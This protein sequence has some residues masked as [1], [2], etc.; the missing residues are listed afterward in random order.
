MTTNA[1][2]PFVQ[3]AAVFTLTACGS[4]FLGSNDAGPAI[5][6]IFPS[7]C[8]INSAASCA[9]ACADGS[10][11]CNNTC[12]NNR[13]AERGCK[14]EKPDGGGCIDE[15]PPMPDGCRVVEPPSCHSCGTFHCDGTD[16][17][18]PCATTC[19]CPD[20]QFCHAG[21]CGNP[22]PG[23]G[24][25]LLCS[26]P[27]AGC[28]YEGGGRCRC[29]IIVCNT[30]GGSEFCNSDDDCPCGEFC[31]RPGGGRC[32]IIE[33]AQTDSACPRSSCH[34]CPPRTCSDGGT[35][36]CATDKDCPSGQKCEDSLLWCESTVGSC[37]TCIA[38][39]TPCMLH[40]DVRADCP[41]G[42]TCVATLDNEDAGG[43]PMYGECKPDGY[44]NSPSDCD[45]LGLAC[46]W[47]CSNHACSAS[48]CGT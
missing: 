9:T 36:G 44:C 21:H 3:L 5:E 10:N 15:C 40:G 27:P 12:I 30:D 33:C 42:Q 11:P 46:P 19:D 38:I 18:A 45:H 39:A 16:A 23:D 20:Q 8:P 25:G 14:V 17:G 7:D 2:R 28:H 1:L 6:C 48:Y 43:A 4:S 24:S 47:T 34:S 32:A 13:C 37:G 26:N 29:G 22:L 41:A 35:P 31:P